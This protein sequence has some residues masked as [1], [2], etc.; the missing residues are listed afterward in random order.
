MPPLTNNCC[1]V[2]WS[3][4]RH[5][6]G[7]PPDPLPP[8]LP[9]FVSV[10]DLD[11]HQQCQSPAS[12]KGGRTTRRD[13]AAPP[14]PNHSRPPHPRPAHRF[15]RFLFFL[16][17]GGR[18]PDCLCR[19]KGMHLFILLGWIPSSPLPQICDAGC[20]LL[21][22]TAGTVDTFISFRDYANLDAFLL[23]I[24]VSRYLCCYN[25]RSKSCA[26]N[27]PIDLDRGSF[28]SGFNR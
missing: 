19:E 3:R 26:E 25:Y 27:D 18:H 5:W 2:Q 28:S 11:Q 9:S 16:A 21:K 6:S 10:S 7:P 23:H 8:S 20:L 17:A 13:A 22:R 14:N 4:T 15:R 12:G 1:Q 24:I